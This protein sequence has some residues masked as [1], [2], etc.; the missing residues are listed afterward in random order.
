MNTQNVIVIAIAIVGFAIALAKLMKFRRAFIVPE[1]YAGLLYH[2]G[3]FVET[4][5]A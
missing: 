4:L 1:G 3:Q 5:K 2:E